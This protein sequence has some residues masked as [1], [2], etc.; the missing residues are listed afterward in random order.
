MP[1]I[2]TVPYRNVGIL[3]NPLGGRVRDRISAIRGLAQGIPGEIY[4]EA[5]N[6]VEF[7][8]VLNEFATRQLDL[9]VIIA[10]DG[11]IHAVL[12]YI[13][14]RGLF[15]PLPPLALIP[16]GTTNMTA[17]DCKVF[18]KPEK[19]MRRLIKKLSQSGFPACITRPVLRIQ[20]GDSPPEYGMFFGTGAIVAAVKYSHERVRN[21]GLTGE[22]V[23]WIVLLR[24]LFSLL[25]GKGESASLHLKTG[26]SLNDD[27]NTD[28]GEYLM[29]FTT[30]LNRLVLGL[31]PYWGRQQ[32]PIHTTFVRRSPR[33]LWCAIWPLLTGRGECLSATDGYRSVN[34]SS[35]SLS[36]TADYI[37]DGEIYYADANLGAVHIS[38][39]DSISV[40][41]LRN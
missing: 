1:E 19:A 34:L 22:K 39:E 40:I 30:S 7:E 5:C 6:Q 31:R 12:S 38:S 3:A 35:L 14:G 13:L 4:R 25:S 32:K 10:G 27:E 37:I 9:L 26:I 29:I 18:G 2:N 24:F 17:K 20:H 21:T 36:M 8:K 41:D 33:R 23:S 28:V 16:A 11:T 15:S